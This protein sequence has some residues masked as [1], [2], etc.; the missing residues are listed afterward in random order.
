MVII[1]YDC[2]CVPQSW[3]KGTLPFA[4]NRYSGQPY[5]FCARQSWPAHDWDGC[6]CKRCGAVRDH[7]HDFVYTTEEDVVL[8]SGSGSQVV[9]SVAKKDCK[10]CGYYEEAE[11]A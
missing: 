5:E 6:R 11:N 3:R 1:E 2:E 4:G 7:E 8:Y 10:R 9:G